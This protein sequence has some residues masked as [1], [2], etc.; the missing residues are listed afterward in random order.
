MKV[1]KRRVT[2]RDALQ[3]LTRRVFLGRS[4]L[5]T[6]GAVLSLSALD[7]LGAR[8]ALAASGRD[9]R[10]VGYGP[11][12]PVA[13]SNPEE[14]AAAGWPSLATFPILALPHGFQYRAFSIIGGILSDGDP[15]P[16]N[17][18]GMAA[19]AHPTNPE[20]VRLIRNQEDRATPGMGSVQGPPETRYDPLGRGG[21]VTLDYDERRHRLV[22]DYISLNGTI[23]NCAGGIGFGSRAWL[24]CEETTSG[25]P[26]W[27][28]PHGYV[29]TVPVNAELGEVPNA[30]PIK[31]MGRFSH[32]AL[33]VDQDTG[34]VYLT[35]DPSGG[36]GAGFYRY[37]P[38][39]PTDLQAGGLLQMLGIAGQPQYDTREGQ[40]QGLVLP[41]AWFEIFDPDPVAAGNTSPTRTFNQGFDQGGAKF[42]RLEGCWWEGGS[43]F[44]V[45][46][47]GGDVKNGDV[48]ADGFREGYGQ[49]WQYAPQEPSGGHLRLLFESPGQAVL[50]SPD[51]LTVTP[52]GGLLLCE[53]DA[54]GR[55]NDMHPLA[56]GII[57]PNRLI[58]ISP[59]GEAFEFAVNRLNPSEFAGACFSPSG[60]TMFANIFGN[61]SACS[62]MTLAITGPWNAG[63]L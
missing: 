13:P 24:T 11:L 3:G 29:F 16:V 40:T 47:S 18:D 54:G 7:R 6:G 8:S 28:Q 53:D 51:N 61:G 35:E 60:R 39:D 50:D 37:L 12:A 44:F 21:N 32:E 26:P 43:V 59:A 56:P 41:V 5:A 58:G 63:P 19:F 49:I 33:A 2:T 25:T 34:V 42:N 1:Q 52:R 20:V 45:A 38:Y 62:G 57:N 4:A 9:L 55:D 48:N 10:G 31:S 17:H 36:V 23:V 30:E 46:T 14:I 22:Q 27:G 15:V